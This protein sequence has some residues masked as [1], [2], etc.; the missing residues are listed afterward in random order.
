MSFCLK[1]HTFG[2]RFL[3]GV[4]CCGMVLFAVLTGC[5]FNVMHWHAQS[6]ADSIKI[7]RYDRVESRY[8]T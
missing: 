3:I 1:K 7:Q 8:L 6:T 2:W 5:D 4:G